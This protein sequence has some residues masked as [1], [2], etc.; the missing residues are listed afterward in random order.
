VQ[1]KNITTTRLRQECGKK[2]CKTSDWGCPYHACMTDDCQKNEVMKNNVD[3]GN[4]KCKKTTTK[5]TGK[6]GRGYNNPWRVLRKY[7][8]LNVLESFFVVLWAD[9]GYP[10]DVIATI[11][12]PLMWHVTISRK[13]EIHDVR[14]LEATNM[15]DLGFQLVKIMEKEIA[16]FKKTSFPRS[17]GAAQ[18][19]KS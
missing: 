3:F 14:R 15:A 4:G 6:K 16:E 18:D 2:K 7:G 17:I 13:N 10:F 1:R 11:D 9:Y 5:V 8:K 19:D 12:T